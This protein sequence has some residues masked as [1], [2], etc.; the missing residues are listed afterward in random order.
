MPRNYNSVRSIQNCKL[1]IEDHSLS[2]GLNWIYEYIIV[3]ISTDS[4]SYL[5]LMLCRERLFM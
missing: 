5:F 4:N 3:H 2:L 1:H